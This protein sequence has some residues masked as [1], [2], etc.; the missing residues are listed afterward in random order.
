MSSKRDDLLKAA[1]KLLWERGYEATSPRDIQAESGAG[2][3]SFY[4]HFDSKLALAVAALDEVSAEMCA[5]ATAETEASGRDRV[6]R[7]LLQARDGLKG[8][9]LGRFASEAAINEPKLR[10]PIERYFTELE[11]YLAKALA[12]AQRAGELSPKHKPRDLATMLVAVV[13]GGYVLSRIHRDKDALH[14]ASTAALALLRD[15]SAATS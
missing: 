9:R 3:G 14:R 13:Q 1:R 6:S 7:F 10:A 15:A 12:D 4:H 5:L 11:R 8:C 2:Q